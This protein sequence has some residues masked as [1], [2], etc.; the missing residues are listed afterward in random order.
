ML[1][2][3]SHYFTETRAREHRFPVPLA[4]G[5]QRRRLLPSLECSPRA[6]AVAVCLD[7]VGCWLVRSTDPS[8][9]SINLSINHSHRS[10]IDQSTRQSI[11]QIIRLPSSITITMI[12][13]IIISGGGGSSSSSSSVISSIVSI[14]SIIGI[15][16][17]SSSTA[18][19]WTPAGP[20]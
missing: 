14:I 19:S 5:G 3:T 10:I 2:I 16:P 15:P 9:C 7:L 6:L 18:G 1:P 13:F 12:M 20:P 17:S 4:D 8:I 11:N